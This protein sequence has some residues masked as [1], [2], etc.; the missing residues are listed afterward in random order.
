MNQKSNKL[1]SIFTTQK[2]YLFTAAIFLYIMGA[3]LARFL[4]EPLKSV[5]FWTGFLY[6]FLILGSGFFLQIHFDPKSINEAV[7]SEEG[8]RKHRQYLLAGLS[9]MAAGGLLAYFIYT[10]PA[11]TPVTNLFLVF[12]FLVMLLYAVPPA[13]LANRGYGEVTL[14]LLVVNVIPAL[15]YAIQTGSLHSMLILLSLPLTS[16]FLAMAISTNLNGYLNAMLTGEKNLVIMLGW[17]LAMDLHD[18]LIVGGFV[19]L[20]LAYVRGLSW[21]VIWPTF[22]ALPVF[23]FSIYEIHRI[24]S[25]IKPRWTLLTFSG[26]AGTGLLLYSLLFTLWF[27]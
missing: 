11:G 3:G 13:N 27:G 16:F 25:G 5:E 26:Y 17:K 8:L 19:L 15:A 24:K 14:I 10:S 12:V 2:I 7:K 21:N 23:I 1:W 18:W 9:L 6:I 4:G 22:I 20:G